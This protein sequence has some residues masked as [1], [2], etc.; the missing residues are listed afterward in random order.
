MSEERKVLATDPFTAGVRIPKGAILEKIAS[1][2]GPLANNVC[3]GLADCG[4]P[5]KRGFIVVF[6]RVLG[7]PLEQALMGHVCGKREFREAWTK[8]L[9]AHNAKLR[10]EEAKASVQKFLTSASEIEPRL[11]AILPGL[12]ARK[13]IRDILLIDARDF[14]RNCATACRSQNGRITGYSTS[15]IRHRFKGEIFFLQDEAI[16]RAKAILSLIKMMREISENQTITAR[17]I[18][19]RLSRFKNLKRDQDEI[20]K[21]ALAGAAALRPSHM[22]RAIEAIENNSRNRQVMI[23]GSTLFVNRRLIAMGDVFEWARVADLAQVISIDT[24]PAPDAVTRHPLS[25]SSGAKPVA[26]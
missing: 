4:T 26:A 6:R 12:E 22:I 19:E 11:H 16:G 25:R 10:A 7:E 18:E 17:E 2:Y 24:P 14:M 8:A 3:C 5:H 13:A 23:E 21:E 1:N 15:H 20:E 9:A